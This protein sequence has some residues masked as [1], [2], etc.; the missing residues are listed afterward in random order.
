VGRRRGGGRQAADP[1]GNQVPPARLALA[2]LA[3]GQ[4]LPGPVTYRLAGGP[5][6]QVAEV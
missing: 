3:A 4:V 1:A 6:D 2:V 5:G